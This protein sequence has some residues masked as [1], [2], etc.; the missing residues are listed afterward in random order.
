MHCP[1]PVILGDFEEYFNEMDLNHDGK[2]SVDELA[3]YMKTRKDLRTKP[4]LRASQVT[5]I[6]AMRSPKK[7]GKAARAPDW[8]DRRAEETRLEWE[9]KYLSD[10]ARQHNWTAQGDSLSQMSASQSQ[11]AFR[12]N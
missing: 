6:E 7:G 3:A 12:Y 4:D 11:P 8:A 10:F 9:E 1:V 5:S 2:I